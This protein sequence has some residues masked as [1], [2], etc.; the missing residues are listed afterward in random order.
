LVPVLGEV[1]VLETQLHVQSA[2]G[3]VETVVAAVPTV[4][5][6]AVAPA[7]ALPSQLAVAVAVVVAAAV[8]AAAASLFAWS[9]R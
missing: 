9:Q 6:V 5:S 4:V 3:P 2:L 1:V 7:V 8:A